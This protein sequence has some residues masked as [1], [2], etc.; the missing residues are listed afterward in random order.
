MFL[1]GNYFFSYSRTQKSIALSSAEA[2]YLSLTGTA[3]EALNIHTA[4]RFLTASPVVLKAFTD[5]SACRGTCARQGVGRIKHLAVRLLW[6]QQAIRAGRL[7]VH[8]V[9]TQQNPADIGTKPLT[10]KRI[11]LLLYILNFRNDD[12]RIGEEEYRQYSAA[13]VIRRLEK[14]F[15]RKGFFTAAVFAAL[16]QRSEGMRHTLSKQETCKGAA[17]AMAESTTLKQASCSITLDSQYSMQLATD[18]SSACPDSNMSIWEA[19][20]FVTATSVAKSESIGDCTIHVES[21]QHEQLYMFQEVVTFVVKKFTR[22]KL[23][24][25]AFEAIMERYEVFVAIFAILAVYL[26]GKFG[27][28]F[29]IRKKRSEEVSTQEK[30]TEEEEE[31]GEE[32]EEAEEETEEEEKQTKKEAKKSPGEAKGKKSE[33]PVKEKK[34]TASTSTASSSKEAPELEEEIVR[35]QALVDE[36]EQAITDLADDLL[37]V[38]N[39]VADKEKRME[40]LEER[41]SKLADYYEK[42]NANIRKHNQE[43]INKNEAFVE[44]IKQLRWKSGEKDKLIENL[45]TISRIKAKE[46]P[47]K[48]E[49][50]HTH[51]QVP[52]TKYHRLSSSHQHHRKEK[53]KER[54]EMKTGRNQKARRK[55]KAK[56]KQKA[57]KEEKERKEKDKKEMKAA[58]VQEKERAR[59]K[60][61][62]AKV[63]E[64]AKRKSTTECQSLCSAAMFGNSTLTR[65]STSATQRMRMEQQESK[66][67]SSREEMIGTES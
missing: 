53:R 8:S 7:T 3:S 64:T 1:D 65:S 31:E 46:M 15:S 19:C 60:E 11:Q 9:P 62:K 41:H 49:Q 32:Q 39:I 22:S 63:Q 23:L 4:L 35:L 42:D 58:K 34:K 16:T 12:Q 66:E 2:E 26:Y 17:A 20:T 28:E 52:A 44:E 40:E 50:P 45:K 10:A 30:E 59:S 25:S 67:Q 37:Q 21:G 47:K 6:L 36:K 54:K 13:A 5:S 24:R 27:D 51:Q 38:R 61:K 48:P 56:G 14:S 33:E 57:R 18:E 43:L 55:Q 29:E